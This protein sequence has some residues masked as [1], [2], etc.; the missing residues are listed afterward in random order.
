MGRTLFLAGINESRARG[1]EYADTYVL[2]D[3]RASA[4]TLRMLKKE[5]AVLVDSFPDYSIVDGKRIE[6]TNHHFRRSLMTGK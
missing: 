1:V 3:N 4:I 6:C 2:A 5:G